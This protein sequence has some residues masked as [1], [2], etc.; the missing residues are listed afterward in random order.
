MAAILN[1][2]FSFSSIYPEVDFNDV[3]EDDLFHQ[4]IETIAAAAIATGYED[5]TFLQ[6]AET[7]RAEFSVF[8]A[9]ALD[10]ER[11]VAEE[12]ASQVVGAL[13]AQDM[14]EFAEHVLPNEGV[15]FSPYAYVD[16]ENDQDFS[17]EEAAQL[18]EDET[19]YTWGVYDGRGN[20]IE[21]TYSHSFM[22]KIM[23]PRTT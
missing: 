21:L 18:S 20:P 2:S 8:L 4:E 1:R 5:G 14:E 11:F 17:A 16:T 23:P 6:D 15:R 13:Q 12:T 9:R 3:N 10:P 22:T 19:V 7:T